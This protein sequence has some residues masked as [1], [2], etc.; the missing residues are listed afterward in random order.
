M[1]EAFLDSSIIWAFVGPREYERDHD[2][3]V[4]IFAS[5]QAERFASESVHLEIRE[6]RRR[7]IRLYTRLIEHFRSGRRPE[8][9]AFD[10]FSRHMADR[11]RQLVRRLRGTQADVEYLRRLGQ[12]EEAK[13]REAWSRIVSPLLPFLNDPYLQDSLRAAVDL[14]MGDAK[15]VTDYLSWAPSRSDAK[16]VTA[17]R[18]L[19]E[20]VRARLDQFLTLQSIAKPTHADFL[21]PIQFLARL[22]N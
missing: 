22:A 10:D 8:D 18:K 12:Q 2:S 17:D 5:P 3:C 20:K 11:A 7:R 9:F 1:E 4:A 16:F 21:D 6:S 13:L 14:T 19:L 15:V